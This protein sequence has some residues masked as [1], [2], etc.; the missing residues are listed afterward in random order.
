MKLKWVLIISICFISCFAMGQSL[1]IGSSFNQT[2]GTV[3]HYF[4][5]STQDMAFVST[6]LLASNMYFGTNA[7][8]FIGSATNIAV[9]PNSEFVLYQGNWIN[10]YYTGSSTNT[11]IRPEVFNLVDCMNNISNRSADFNN[12]VFNRM[13]V[14]VTSPTNLRSENPI[15]WQTASNGKYPYTNTTTVSDRL[16]CGRAL[17]IIKG[18][19]TITLKVRTTNVGRMFLTN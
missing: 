8:L 5:W 15:V 2:N 10:G 7:V 3:K 9:P 11:Y 16:V 19:D 4:G 17:T 18:V 12:A 1:V 6:T 13:Y 14:D